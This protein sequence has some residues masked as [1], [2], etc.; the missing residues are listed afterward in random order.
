[1]GKAKQDSISRVTVSY[2]EIY[3]EHV[4]DLLRYEQSKMLKSGLEIRE[5]KRRGVF[6]PDATEVSVSTYLFEREE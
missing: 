3:N 2:L 5:D 4:Y 6:I 1:M